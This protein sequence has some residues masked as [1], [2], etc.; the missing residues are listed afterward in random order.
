MLPVP[1]TNPA[2]FMRTCALATLSTDTQLTTIKKQ[3]SLQMK[4]L[5]PDAKQ[6]A[7]IPRP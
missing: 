7:H 2:L 5:E 4:T 3:T 6:P 1:T